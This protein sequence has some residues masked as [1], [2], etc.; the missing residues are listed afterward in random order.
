MSQIKRVWLKRHLEEVVFSTLLIFLALTISGRFILKTNNF[1]SLITEVVLCLTIATIIQLFE[2]ITDWLSY[3]YYS[4][5]TGLT[6]VQ[7]IEAHYLI[8]MSPSLVMI[9]V[10]SGKIQNIFDTISEV[11]SSNS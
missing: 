10:K 5:K 7:I 8:G 3:A 4:W 11:K 2:I 1:P 6:V 9:W